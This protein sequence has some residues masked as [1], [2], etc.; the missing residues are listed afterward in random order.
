MTHRTGRTVHT[1]PKY[2]CNRYK[3]GIIYALRCGNNHLEVL[4]VLQG[5]G[6]IM[7]RRHLNSTA[8]ET[9]GPTYN[10][11][12]DCTGAKCTALFS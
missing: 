11:I 7:L 6:L 2:R 5:L 3:Q 9:V 8:V 10:A 12:A 1:G 4:E